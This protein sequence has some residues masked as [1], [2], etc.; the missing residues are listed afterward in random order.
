VRSSSFSHRVERILALWILAL[1]VVA[2]K[3][4]DRRAGIRD[5]SWDVESGTPI[6]GSDA[7]LVRRAWLARCRPNRARAATLPVRA[8]ASR[9]DE[10]RPTS[11]PELDRAGTHRIGHGVPY[12]AFDMAGL[13]RACHS[14]TV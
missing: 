5:A 14:H 10:S 2:A 6:V 13:Y 7:K 1:Y 11:E 4:A 8:S 9:P 12:T 3:Q